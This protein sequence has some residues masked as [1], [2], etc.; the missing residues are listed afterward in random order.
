MHTKMTTHAALRRLW[1]AAVLG[2]LAG[3]AVFFWV[4]GPAP[5]NTGWDGWILNGYDEWDVQQHYAGWLLFRN[6]HWAFPLGYADTIA[7]PGGTAISYTDSLP[8]VSIALKLLRGALP[9]TFQWFGWYTLGCFALQGAAGGL[10]AARGGK[11]RVEIALGGG[12]GG[13]LFACLPTL[14]ERAFRHTALASQWLFLF[15]LFAWLESRAALTAGGKA[16]GWAAWFPVLGFAAVGIHPYFLP[17]VL[18]CALLAAIDRGRLTHRWG[19][20]ALQFGAAVAASAAGGVLCGALG[21]GGGL[22]REG[23]GEFSMNGNALWNPSSRG[24]Y[25]W[26]RLLPA[27][28]QLAGQYDGFNYLGLGVLGLL[29]AALALALAAAVR[30]RPAVAAWRRRNAPAFAACALLTLFALSNT[31]SYGSASFTIPLPGPLLSLCG[32]FRSSGRM[33]YLVAAMMLTWAIYTLRAALAALPL[34][35]AGKTAAFC[36]ALALVLGV[37]GWDLSAV[38]A[39]KRAKFSPETPITETV[40]NAEE[41]AALGVGHTKLLAAGDV[42]DDRLRTLAILAG[43]QG[44]ATN[45]D[46]AVSGQ[47]NAAAQSRADTAAALQAGQYETDAVYVTTDGGVWESWQQIFAGEESLA[48]FVV[49][50]CY[51]M[52]P[53]V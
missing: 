17:L 51:F 47:H 48:F 10:L 25:T 13:A 15:A 2:A 24:G 28:P 32:I 38:A 18:V 34:R 44:L 8:W 20:A 6:S 19:A 27:Q 49:D 12:L 43:K 36:A 9:A 42:R 7:W 35:P 3:A 40:A 29:A 50:S 22:S 37:Q 41:T 33:F 11:T 5:L 21:A 26:S 14:W 52:V 53:R 31:V 45:L 39:E 46:I 16:R 23:Y 4:Y 1:P 30:R